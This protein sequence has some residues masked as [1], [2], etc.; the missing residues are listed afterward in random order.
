MDLLK[1]D[2][3]IEELAGVWLQVAQNMGKK[4][5]EITSRCS[6]LIGRIISECRE[7]LEGE[8]E[9]YWTVKPNIMGSVIASMKLN[10]T[11]YWCRD[12]SLTYTTDAD[13]NVIK[14]GVV[15]LGAL[16]DPDNP[17]TEDGNSTGLSVESTPEDYAAESDLLAWMFSQTSDSE[18][19]RK[20]LVLKMEGFT[21]TEIANDLGITKA[22]VN[23]A[24]NLLK[25]K[26]RNYS[27]ID[28]GRDLE[29]L[30]LDILVETIQ[31]TGLSKTWA[32]RS[33]RPVVRL[34][35]SGYYELQT[36]FNKLQEA[37]ERGD[38]YIQ[39]RVIQFK[40]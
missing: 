27:N 32:T 28:T 34:I 31:G 37:R 23:D 40:L 3:G 17:I 7:E 18:L 38:K 5:D 21:N 29:H 16:L 9:L 36:G 6:A 8:G 12:S 1:T 13:D 22:S 11:T 25:Q 24:S 33:Q 14:C 39:C 19:Q 35:K 26:V 4:D 20:V 30:D 15:H 10:R 2:E